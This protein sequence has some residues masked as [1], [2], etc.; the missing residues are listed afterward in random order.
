MSN[1]SPVLIARTLA[2]VG[3]DQIECG[4]GAR[5]PEIDLGSL[6]GRV[7]RVLLSSEPYA[8]RPRDVAEVES[9]DRDVN[10]SLIDAEMTSWY[11]SRAIAG[12]T[13]LADYRKSTPS[14]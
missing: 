7:D 4:S 10:A 12:M 1:D 2:A 13:Y 14:N 8:F 11:G 3:W 5:Y 6:A 9:L